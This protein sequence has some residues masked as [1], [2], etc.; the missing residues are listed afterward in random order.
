M[1]HTLVHL[2]IE[3]GFGRLLHGSLSLGWFTAAARCPSLART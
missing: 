1:D 3:V 2:K